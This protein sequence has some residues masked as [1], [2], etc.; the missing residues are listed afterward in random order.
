MLSDNAWR[1]S[2]RTISG[3]MLSSTLVL[4][5]ACGT[6]TTE[7]SASSTPTS[8]SSR[9]STPTTTSSRSSTGSTSSSS[10][11]TGA[12]PDDNVSGQYRV[13]PQGQITDGGQVFDV[14]CGAWFGLEG[15][16]EPVDAETNASGAPLELYIGNMWWVDSG[17]SIEQTMD[18][19]KEL[20]INMIRLPIAPQTLDANDPQGT[21][22]VYTNGAKNSSGVL[23]NTEA[24][25]PYD[26]AR[27]ALEEFIKLADQK[28]LKVLVDIHSCSNYVGWRAG[29]L[30]ANPPYVDRDR[31]DY[32]F[33]REDYSCG[34]GAAND[35]PYNET[36]WLE[37]L[38]EIASLPGKLNV[39]NII[40]IDIFNE[41]WDYTWDQWAT[42]SEKAFKAIDAVNK[43]LLIFVEGIGSGLYDETK[44][45]HGE[46]D[47][48]PNWGENFWGFTER[49]LQIP[50]NRVVMSPHTYG[51]S[52]F[53][54]KQHVDG[55]ACAGMEG[56]EAGDNNCA[57]KI[58]SSRVEAGWE[59]HF[60]F[61]RDMNYAIVIGEFGGN[62]DWPD[63][64]RA[65]EK[66][67]W[68]HITTA[69]D[70]DW[71]NALVDYMIKEKIEGCYW[72]INPE[73]GDTGGI[74]E[75][76]YH[77]ENAEDAWGQWGDFDTRKTSLLQRLWR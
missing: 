14:H 46:E 35:S 51:P 76:I 45:P 26:N 13:N 59:E 57:I 70:E 55:A 40:G 47:L 19:I 6:P 65:D 58:D 56:D 16:H 1:I 60:G 8:T 18:E 38:R 4:M 69:V 20:G 39:D 72:S 29:K 27:K 3:L 32:D 10:T 53:V 54:Q 30:N 43:D 31:E 21:G 64:T 41:P 71:Q 12:Y 74:Y 61:L 66:E 75:H 28:D 36:L 23:K 77:P 68:S 50:R 7:S 62:M 17:R 34:G 5:S 25:Y 67:R 63:R 44:I 73:S 33:T 49:P 52:V 11:N 42:L 48:N 37:D 15:Q 9:S 24:E 2:Q 22:F